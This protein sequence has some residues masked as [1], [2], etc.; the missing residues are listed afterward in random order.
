M[1]A[2]TTAYSSADL[3]G[4]LDAYKA[5]LFAVVKPMPSAETHKKVYTR[6]GLGVGE[7]YEWVKHWLATTS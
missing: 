2:C 6:V 3:W 1:H 4:A 5:V 7:D